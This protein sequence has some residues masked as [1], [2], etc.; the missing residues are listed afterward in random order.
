[1]SGTVIAAG[2]GLLTNWLT[3]KQKKAKAKT[4][5]EVKKIQRDETWEVAALKKPGKMLR[6]VSYSMFGLPM[7]IS[8]V[9]PEQGAKIWANLDLVPDW[10]LTTFISINGAVWGIAELKQPLAAI[11]GR[12]KRG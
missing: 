9:W 2:L 10:Y 8:V 6:F 1:M 3:G 4:D 7:I 12:V 11:A 5:V